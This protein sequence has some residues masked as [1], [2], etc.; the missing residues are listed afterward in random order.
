MTKPGIM[1]PEGLEKHIFM[2]CMDSLNESAD[3]I[4]LKRILIKL[5]EAWK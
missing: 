3:E 4:M 1:K 2:H 5:C